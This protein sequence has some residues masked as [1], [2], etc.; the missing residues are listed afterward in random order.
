MATRMSESKKPSDPQQPDRRRTPRVD[1]QV[2][3]AIQ[4]SGTAIQTETKNLSEAGV[5]CR[6]DQFVPP[7]TKLQLSFDLP[8]N[9]RRVRVQCEGAVVRVEPIVAAG[10]NGQ[11]HLGIFFTDI[12]DRDRST[13]SQFVRER[14]SKPSSAS[15]DRA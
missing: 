1:E 12:S 15:S 9:G 4:S 8:L 11:Y 3:L 2:A 13:I 5:Y 7:M 6:V 14:L 10:L